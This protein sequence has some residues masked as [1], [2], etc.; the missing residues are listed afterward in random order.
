V[1]ATRQLAAARTLP[2]G[3]LFPRRS[4]AIIGAAEGTGS[5]LH[6]KPRLG[7]SKLDAGKGLDSNAAAIGMFSRP[8]ARLPFGE[9][10]R[11]ERARGD[12]CALCS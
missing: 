4:C 2:I 8:L 11:H 5:S 7:H 12:G 6:R 10:L 1:K 9:V 3:Q